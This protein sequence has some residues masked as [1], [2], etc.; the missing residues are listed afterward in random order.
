MNKKKKLILIT[1]AL[2]QDGI[3]LSKILIKKKFHVKGII[4]P[5]KYQNKLNDV[6]YFKV[7]LS[8]VNKLNKLILNLK[9][10]YLVHF[11]SS[12]P[13]Y[14]EKK[15][16]KNFDTK[17]KTQTI[18]L[19]N[20]LQ[21]YSRNTIFIF[22]NSSQ[23]FKYKKQAVNES[24]KINKKSNYSSF[25][26]DILKHM[27]SLKKKT[28]FKF[29]NLILFNHDSIYRNKKFL[30]PR[31]VKS[32]KDNNYKFLKEIY[33]KNIYE[34]FSHAEDICNGIYKLINKKIIIDN[35]IFSS[36]KKTSINSVINYLLKKYKKNKIYLKN[37][38]INHKFVVGNN[39]LAKKIL[40]WK[41]KKNIFI[42]ADEIYKNFN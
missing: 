39:S 1:G 41:I 9:P 38:K 33:T 29:I 15:S 28:K 8:N 18:N 4:K 27:I 26:I 7:D 23:I 37:T 20:S 35:L 34:D 14:L 36:G 10:D 30:I 25:R 5:K 22:A 13:S 31:I 32:I 3:I 21:R 11:G 19:I 12:N 24:S 42:A 17:N 40:N 6:K 16:K 2:G